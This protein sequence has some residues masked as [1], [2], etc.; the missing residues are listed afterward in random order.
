[1][2]T[3]SKDVLGFTFKKGDHK[4]VMWYNEDNTELAVR[5]VLYWIQSEHTN[6]E[7]DD[8]WS[9]LEAMRVLQHQ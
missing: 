7:F 4:Y 2:D 6:L 3:D 9:I 5:H 1:M 8:I